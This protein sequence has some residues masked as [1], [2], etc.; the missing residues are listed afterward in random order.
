MGYGVVYEECGVQSYVVCNC[1]VGESVPF[2]LVWFVIEVK[3]TKDCIGDMPFGFILVCRVVAL[4]DCVRIV[5]TWWGG[6]L[7]WCCYLVLGLDG[8]EEGGC[9]HH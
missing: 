3:H 7:S 4:F 9:G 8:C 5:H 2:C 1:G 6:G